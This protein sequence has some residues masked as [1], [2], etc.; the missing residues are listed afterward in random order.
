MPKT[1]YEIDTFLV[2]KQ[3]SFCVDNFHL[4]KMGQNNSIFCTVYSMLMPL[5]VAQTGW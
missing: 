4:A 3:G 2:P 5:H 1:F